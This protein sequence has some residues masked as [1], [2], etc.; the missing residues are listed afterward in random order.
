MQGLLRISTAQIMWAMFFGSVG[1]GVFV[2][3]KKQQR[4][5]PLIVGIILMAFPYFISNTYLLIA[6]GIGLIASLFVFRF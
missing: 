3:G 4:L 6:I 2:Y 1:L 5:V